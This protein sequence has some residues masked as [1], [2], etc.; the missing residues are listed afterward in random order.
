MLRCIPTNTAPCA[1]RPR[2]PWAT[3]CTD[4]CASHQGGTAPHFFCYSALW[5]HLAS[6]TT[7]LRRRQYHRQPLRRQ[8]HR[9]QQ[10]R[11][12]SRQRCHG[13]PPRMAHATLREKVWLL[14][15]LCLADDAGDAF[16][17]APARLSATPWGATE[18]QTGPILSTVHLVRSCHVFRGHRGA[19][20]RSRSPHPYSLM[21]VCVCLFGSTRSCHG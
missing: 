4:L 12:S 5:V 16:R 21:C 13:W 20:P 17:P 8:Q 18:V 9:R 2:L 6:P 11:H 10:H 19:P 7:R 3:A 14:C 1:R 15:Q